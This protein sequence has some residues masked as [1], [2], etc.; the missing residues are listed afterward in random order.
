MRNIPAIKLFLG[1]FIVVPLVASA[2]PAR[3]TP[4]SPTTQVVVTV[5]DPNGKAI[6]GAAATF[7]SNTGT[8]VGQGISDVSGQITVDIL[9]PS[10]MTEDD[11]TQIYGVTVAA[12]GYTPTATTFPS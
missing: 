7:T 11:R 2:V 5:T 1:L 6:E 12:A 3:A 4:P 9:L 10:A 8:F